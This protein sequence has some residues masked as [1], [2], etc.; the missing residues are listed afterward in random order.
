MQSLSGLV[1]PTLG[2]R[3]SKYWISRLRARQDSAKSMD[4]WPNPKS[5]PQRGR[6]TQARR[7]FPK[8]D[9]TFG[10]SERRR[11]LRPSIQ[12]S[13]TSTNVHGLGAASASSNSSN[14]GSGSS[15]SGSSS[16]CHHHEWQWWWSNGSTNYINNSTTSSSRRRRQRIKRG[17]YT[18]SLCRE[19]P[20]SAA[21]DDK[22]RCRLPL[23][24]QFKLKT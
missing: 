6:T 3:Y 2:L 15:G 20:T 13:T 12:T 10:I 23:H 18:I 9:K 11:Q 4:S 21:V 8:R 24:W 17:Q 1:R 5:I 22:P 14:S 7:R 16:Q 19:P